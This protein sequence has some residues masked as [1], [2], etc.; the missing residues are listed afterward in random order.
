MS[1]PAQ[2][3]SVSEKQASSHP[4]EQLVA[5]QDGDSAAADPQTSTCLNTEEQE[6]TDAEKRDKT[7]AEQQETQEGG[8]GSDGEEG[9]GVKRKREEA[10]REDEMGQ[11]PEKK[12]VKYP[13]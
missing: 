3:A 6:D 4:E 11:T 13:D 12:K 9:K 5:T 2:E 1:E 10:H 7:E 8:G